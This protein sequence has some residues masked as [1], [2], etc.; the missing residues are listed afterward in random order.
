MKLRSSDS[1][2]NGYVKIRHH[3]PML[4]MTAGF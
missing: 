1:D 2:V 4:F 3:G